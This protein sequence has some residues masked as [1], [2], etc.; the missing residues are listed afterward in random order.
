MNLDKVRSGLTNL[1]C[2]VWKR[3]QTEPFF[4][5]ASGGPTPSNDLK[6]GSV[7]VVVV[8]LLVLV[9]VMGDGWW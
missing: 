4:G 9:V 5:P 6:S 3:R 8:V 1:D 2:V 7:V